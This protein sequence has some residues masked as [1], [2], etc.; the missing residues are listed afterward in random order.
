MMAML[1]VLPGAPR[2]T[3]LAAPLAVS[4][5]GRL[6]TWPSTGELLVG[7]P[8]RPAWMPS[9]MAATTVVAKMAISTIT[10]AV[11]I[12]VLLLNV[13][14]GGTSSSVLPLGRTG[15]AKS[16]DELRRAPLPLQ[17]LLPRRRRPP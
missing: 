7:W 3:L 14:I 5:A 16:S 17:F 13:V 11:A 6:T 10:I 9:Y 1:P 15:E 2:A 8:W 12:K 4:T